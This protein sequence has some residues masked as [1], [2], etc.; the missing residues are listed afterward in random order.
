MAW[1]VNLDGVGAVDAYKE[2]ADVEKGFRNLK[3][4]IELRPIYH[5]KT[6]RVKGH[7]F[8]ATLSFL[9]QR[10]LQRF[11]RGGGVD[12]GVRE[13]MQALETVRVVEFEVADRPH[14]VV[15]RPS[16][17]AAAILKALGIKVHKPPRPGC[18]PAAM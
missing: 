18:D 3:D 7:I 10:A 16:S 2:L 8:I 6:E 17:H 13:A 9:L 15:T 14:K 1:E 11:L 12:L 5:H 4:I